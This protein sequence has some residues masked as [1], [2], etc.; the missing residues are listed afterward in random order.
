MIFYKK[1]NI[2]DFIYE[3]RYDIILQGCN[4]F[5]KM[6]DGI[7]LQFAQ[8]FPEVLLADLKTQF[9]DKSKLGTFVP[10][11]IERFDNKFQILNCYT[12][13]AFAGHDIETFDYFD[14]DS[15]ETILKKISLYDKK[16]RIGMPL[17]GSGH[18]GGDVERILQLIEKY[19][20]K[21]NVEIALY[22]S[23]FLPKQYMSLK[24]QLK[25]SWDDFLEAVKSLWV[26]S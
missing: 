21:H 14:Y 7:A 24:N 17:I 22:N 25:I 26:L 3:G 18:A 13:F 4:C 9:K 1:G 11:S 10:I 2:F 20:S 16:T 23:Q 12:Q 5:C 8:H 6:D 15:F 19:L